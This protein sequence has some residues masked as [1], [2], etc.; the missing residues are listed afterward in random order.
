MA[1]HLTLLL[2]LINFF[3]SS[4]ITSTLQAVDVV[5]EKI[6]LSK[7]GKKRQVIDSSIKQQFLFNTLADLLSLNTGIF[8]KNYG[9]GALAT[10]SLRGGN[11]SQT[12]V[13]WNG[14]NIQNPM[15]GQIDLGII[16]TILFENVEVEYAGS[17][18]LWGSGAISGSILLNNVHS[19]NKGLS[20]KINVCAGSFGL[21][22]SSTEVNYSGKRFLTSTKIYLNS[23]E[24]NFKYKDTSDKEQPLKQQQF[25][26]YRL[27]GL[28][29]ELKFLINNRQT[30]S[31]N[32]WLNSAE[33]R[34]PK[35]NS[36]IDPK[37][38]QFDQSI[39]STINWNYH[40]NQLNS[41]IR[42][43]FFNDKIDYTDSVASIFSKS[44]VNTFIAE[45]EN[46]IKWK[47]ENIFSFG[48]NYTGN[49]AI[50]NNYLG[51]KTLHRLALVVGNKF[52][53]LNKKLLALISLRG[54]YY[55]TG[56]TPVTGNIGLEY[57]LFKNILAKIN[58]AKVYRHPTLNELFWQ[59]GGNINLKPEE[60][61][62]SEGELLCNKQVNNVLVEFSGAAYSRVINDWILWV[63]SGGGRTSPMNIQKVWSRGTESNCKFLY[64]KNKLRVFA[65]L[66]TAYVLST[67]LK[68]YQQNSEAEDKQLIY[69]PRYMANANMGLGFEKFTVTYFQQYV[70]YRFTTSD[71]LEWLS[72]YHYSSIK[73]NYEL[74]TQN[75]ALKIYLAYNNVF[76]K[77]YE[78][79]ANRP[80]PLQNFEIGISIRYNKP[81]KT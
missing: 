62:T 29:Q 70:G 72:P 78:V 39:R 31:A 25:A 76:N 33:R 13:L 37:T 34:L 59:P 67:T 64:Q 50:T 63:P 75:T 2:V 71:N 79:L 36:N 19:F 54:E 48:G 1:M 46:F 22:N 45:N 44:T 58:V 28:M 43:G 56:A 11:A 24:N 26:G 73:L 21:L 51:T 23:S 40:S 6:D 12:A 9:P 14:L 32:V 7:H 80:M 60:G 55:S 66:S 16:P 38:Y 27:F 52:S 35:F 41:V 30:L 53:L 65:Q 10:T 77:N 42:G 69:T 74:P 81:N 57:K 15:L 8:I 61:F 68:S 18:S 17:A 20:S 47:N 3:A 5:A 49:S 4:Q